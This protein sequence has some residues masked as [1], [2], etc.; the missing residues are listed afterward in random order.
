[1]KIKR[2]P[3]IS[4]VL[5]A[6]RTREDLLRRA[7]NVIIS[8]TFED[9][10]LIIVN[11]GA[12]ERVKE[13][14]FSYNN[15]VS[16]DYGRN[17]S[18]K[19]RYYERKKAH[20][21]QSKACNL[22]LKNAQGKYV[23]FHDHDDYLYSHRGTKYSLE[24]MFKEINDE[25]VDVLFFNCGTKDKVYRYRVKNFNLYNDDEK[26]YYDN[27]FYKDN[28]AS[29]SKIIKVSLLKDNN[30]FWNPNLKITEE[31]DFYVRY[32]FHAKNIK[33]S[34]DELYFY[35]HNEESLFST[36]RNN[37]KI[38]YQDIKFLSDIK[39]ILL[40]QNM[41]KK[42]RLSLIDTFADRY[43]PY[44]KEWIL[45]SGEVEKAKKYAKKYLKMLDLSEKDFP[46]VSEDAREMILWYL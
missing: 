11:D 22:G 25:D 24:E 26:A 30:V 8:Q 35:F 18:A 34:S 43:Y 23:L 19:I 7:I 4:I 40:K 29:F 42:V 46:F 3:K 28:Y 13:I 44:I 21:G 32:I 1:M 41:Y 33:F 10:E 27:L 31:L 16:V 15:Q 2:T 38:F 14:V 12:D 9:W 20:G 45:Y 6:F 5:S 17:K 39:N 37:G 36:N